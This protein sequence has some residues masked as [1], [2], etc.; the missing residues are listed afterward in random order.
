MIFGRKNCNYYKDWEVRFNL[1][2]AQYATIAEQLT[3][4]EA[5]K[6]Y[7]IV[8]E[9]LKDKSNFVEIEVEGNTAHVKELEFFLKKNII[10]V[11]M[12]RAY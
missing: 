2:S 12:H 7:E 8:K 4:A 5:L 1:I 9:K 11:E 10:S 6:I 3:R